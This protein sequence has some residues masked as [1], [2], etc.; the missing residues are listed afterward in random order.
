MNREEILQKA[1]QENKNQDVFEQEAVIRAGSIAT[2][3][4]LL[5]CCGIAALEV[6]LTNSIS[7]SSWTIYF[8]ILSTTFF[9]K[10]RILHRRHECMVAIIYL[11]FAIAFLTLYILPLVR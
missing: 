8:G 2:K 4:G 7:F 11:V 3:V 10:Y 9:V 5:L 1:R 6:I